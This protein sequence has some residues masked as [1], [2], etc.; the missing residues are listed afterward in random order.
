MRKNIT[1]IRDLDLIESEL[2]TNVAG[3]LAL[4]RGVE[5]ITQIA[6]PFLYQDKNIYIFFGSDNEYFEKIRFNDYACFTIIKTGQTQKTEGIDFDPTY[7]FF[8]ISIKGK[9]RNIEDNKLIEDLRQNYLIK[10]KKV[11]EGT[12]NFSAINRIVIIDSEEIQALE[13]TGG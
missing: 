1:Q 7:N 12:V 6:T 8:S 9:I 2:K 10:Y 11:V 5:K 3:V 4:K 13:E